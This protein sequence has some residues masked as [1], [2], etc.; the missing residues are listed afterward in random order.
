MA[1][2]RTIGCWPPSEEP[3]R[4]PAVPVPV[5]ACCPPPKDEPNRLPPDVP[6]P[7]A[8]P[9]SPPPEAPVLGVGLLIPA[10]CPNMLGCCCCCCASRVGLAAAGGAPNSDE[11][12]RALPPAPKLPP[13]VPEGCDVKGDDVVCCPNRELCC[14]C[15][16]GAPEVVLVPA[17]PNKGF[18]ALANKL[19]PGAPVLP[20]KR[21]DCCPSPDMP[22]CVDVCVCVC[23]SVYL[24][25]SSEP[26][27]FFNLCFRGRNHAK[28]SQ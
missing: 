28:K 5:P 6:V 14:C 3:K 22:D 18:C 24:L 21:L 20:P 8:E 27:F 9:K 10:G 23:V 26:M 4:P 7:A 16:G 17:L 15:C 25:S 1:N 11:E 19:L 12:P 2:G 13:K